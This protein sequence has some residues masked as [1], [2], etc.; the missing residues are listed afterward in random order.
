MAT[1][2]SKVKAKVS[3]LL[4]KYGCYYEMPIPTGFGKSG[5]DYTGCHLGRF[6]VVETKA[7]VKRATPRQLLTARAVEDAGGTTFLVNEERGYEALESWLKREDE[8]ED[9]V[10]F[11]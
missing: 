5:L 1:P 9:A 7:G 3:A 2:E 4:K 10:E 11:S 6:F 8:I